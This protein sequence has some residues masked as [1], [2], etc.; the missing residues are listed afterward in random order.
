MPCSSWRRCCTFE[1]FDIISWSFKVDFAG[2]NKW[3]LPAYPD[4]VKTFSVVAKLEQKELY[5]QFYNIVLGR[6][7]IF[8]YKKQFC[9]YYKIAHLRKHISHSPSPV[10]IN[11]PYSTIVEVI[12]ITFEIMYTVG[13]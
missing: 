2:G 5:C 4:I 13:F 1:V 6:A 3:N 9:F 10:T 11:Y 8:S 12:V 7:F